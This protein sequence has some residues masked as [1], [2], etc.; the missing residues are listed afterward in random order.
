MNHPTPAT[1]RTVSM[2]IVVTPIVP[3]LILILPMKNPL[4]SVDSILSERDVFVNFQTK[5][6]GVL[7]EY[8]EGEMLD[9][10]PRDFILTIT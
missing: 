2:K 9:V 3:S 4:L 6:H 5:F 7:S 1:V 8:R 10:Y